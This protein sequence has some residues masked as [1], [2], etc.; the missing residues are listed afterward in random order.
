MVLSIPLNT[1]IEKNLI[2]KILYQE[3]ICPLESVG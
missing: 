2:N 1:R 3:V